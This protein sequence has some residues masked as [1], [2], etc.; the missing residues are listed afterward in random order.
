[1]QH[2]LLIILL[3]GPLFAQNLWQKL[4]APIFYEFG[5]QTHYQSNPLNLS[6][7]ELEKV[8]VDADYL[9]NI[10][11]SSSN[12]L[13]LNAKFVY[14]PRLFDGR[15][16]RFSVQLNHH[17]YQDIPLRNYQSYS[18]SVRQSMGQYRYLEVGYWILPEYYL[19][20]YRFKDPQTLIYSREVCN[21][22]TDRLWLGWQHRML[23]KNTLEYRLTV[24]NEFY[25]APFAMYDLVMREGGVKFKLGQFKPFTLTTEL[26]YGAADNNNSYDE[27]DRSYNYLN[28]RPTLNLRAG[29]YQ[30]RI[31]T[32]YDQRAYHS[33]YTDDP[34]HAGRYQDE[35]RVELTLLPRLN[36]PVSI[37][38]F[39]GYR[40]RRVDSVDAAV[41]DLK[42]FDRYWFGIRF[43]F[44]SVIDMYY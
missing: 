2:L 13:T 27:K 11:N 23:R 30:L 31:A 41:R 1:M 43:G 14:S 12:V 33:E 18:G 29:K 7:L 15:K 36:G 38:P 20:N 24:R 28:I 35:F 42:S 37:A 6:D 5:L 21:F 25:Q 44:K 16:T 40:E 32:R 26:Q 19:R 8:A 22:G 9:N 39:A 10:E 17:E 4:A 34:L 3:A